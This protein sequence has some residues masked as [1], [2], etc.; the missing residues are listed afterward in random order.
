[1]VSFFSTL[2]SHF[3]SLPKWDF[4]FF[5]LLIVAFLSPTD[6]TFRLAFNFGVFTLFVQSS[7]GKKGYNA[8]LKIEDKQRE[9]V[10]VFLSRLESFMV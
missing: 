4:N 10:R 2:S 9:K 3:H 1:M 5:L 7:E 6:E 8:F